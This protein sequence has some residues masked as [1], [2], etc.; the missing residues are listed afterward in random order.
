MT[1]FNNAIDI[2]YREITT[3]L[4]R[5][6]DSLRRQ[7]SK[8]R[9]LI[10]MGITRNKDNDKWEYLNEQNAT[11]RILPVSQQNWGLREPSQENCVVLDSALHWKWNAVRCIISAATICIAN[12]RQCP[13]PD[14]RKGIF[15]TKNGLVG[16]D[17]PATGKAYQTYRS[18]ILR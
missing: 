8:R 2:L 6:S 15:I 13:L 16:V 5:I 18:D 14:V 17:Q 3:W 10:W 9:I 1:I 12:P 7:T 4:K 11:E